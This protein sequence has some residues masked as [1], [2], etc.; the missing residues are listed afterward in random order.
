MRWKNLFIIIIIFSNSVSAK[1]W[2]NLKTYQKTTQKQNLSSSD[3]LKSDRLK[4]TLVWQRANHYNLIHNLPKEYSNINQRKAFYMWLYNELDKKGHEVVWV[5]MAHYISTKLRTMESFPFAIFTSKR[6]LKYANS[7]SELVFN[8]AFVSLNSI[9][10]SHKI[11]TGNNAVQWD[12]DMLYKEQYFWIAPIYKTMD[13][14][15]LKKFQRIAKGTF[16]YAW[17]VPKAIRFKGNLSKAEAR[18]KYAFDT[19]R[20]YCKNRYK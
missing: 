13:E 7:G 10:Q 20:A 9:Y 17:V 2:R 3:W 6:I 12:R 8:D 15:S 4:N 14:R 19:L 5:K 16:L 18:Y 11:F 1:E